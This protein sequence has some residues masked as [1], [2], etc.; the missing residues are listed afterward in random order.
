[1]IL[2]HIFESCSQNNFTSPCHKKTF[3]N[4]MWWMLT[5]FIV[6]KFEMHTKT[7]PLCCTPEPNIMLC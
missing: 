1:M 5:T 4:Y 6:M 7:E 2:Y 3:S